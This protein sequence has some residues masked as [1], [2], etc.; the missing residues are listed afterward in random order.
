MKLKPPVHKDHLSIEINVGCLTDTYLRDSIHM[1]SLFNDHLPIYKECKF[2]RHIHALIDTRIASANTSTSLP[3]SCVHYV[4]MYNNRP[5]S[6]MYHCMSSFSV[7]AP[8][9]HMAHTSRKG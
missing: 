6:R 7:S 8:H 5:R 9:S 2:L 3:T 4:C 1:T